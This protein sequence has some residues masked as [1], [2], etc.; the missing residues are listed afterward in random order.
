MNTHDEIELPPLPPP[1]KKA[2]YATSANTKSVRDGVEMSGYEKEP[3][4]FD[5][6]QMHE[7]ARIAIEADRKQRGEPV[8]M[9]LGQKAVAAELLACFK[10][11][12]PMVCVL[13]N[14][15]ARDGAD[16]MQEILSAAPQPAAIEA[17]LQ[18]TEQPENQNR[19]KR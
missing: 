7:Y 13:G 1:F 11:W 16:L 12:E 2:V 4:L 8:A 5:D 9:T 3:P 14:V 17:P 15:R 18:S 19:Q 10:A 6:A